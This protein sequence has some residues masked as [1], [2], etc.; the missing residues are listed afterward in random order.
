[1]PKTNA[2][3]KMLCINAAKEKD[4]LVYTVKLIL[5]LVFWKIHLSR[6]SDGSVCSILAAQIELNDKATQFKLDKGTEITAISSDIC[7]ITQQVLALLDV[8]VV[9]KLSTDVSSYG[10][11]AILLQQNNS[12]WQPVTFT[13]RAMSDTK[14]R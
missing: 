13:S 4:T 1:M 8:N 10:L 5:F 2:Q 11:G 6:H 7:G 3:L 9:F 12:S 14:H